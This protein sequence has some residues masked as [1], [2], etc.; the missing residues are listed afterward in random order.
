MGLFIRSLEETLYIFGSNGTIKAGGK[1]VNI[2][3]EWNFSDNM[4]D[5]EVVKNEYSENPENVYGFGHNPLYANVINAIETGTK[6]L[7]DAEAGT[8]ALEL[9]LAIYESAATRKPVKLPLVDASSTDY[10]GRFG[11]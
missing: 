5:A 8:R 3:E 6:P 4:D 7:V 2:I 9:I 1:S 10:E 11:K